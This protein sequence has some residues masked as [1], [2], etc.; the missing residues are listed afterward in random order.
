MRNITLPQIQQL[1]LEILK[2]FHNYCQENGLKYALYAGTLLGAIRHKGYIPWDDDIDIMMPRG[3][4]EKLY[5]LIKTK[6]L[7]APLELHSVRNDKHHN[8]P[9]FKVCDAR[10]D[11]TVTYLRNDIRCPVWIDIFPLDGIPDNEAER[12]KHLQTLWDIQKEMEYIV[13]PLRFSANPLRL[14]K[15][16][17][18]WARYHKKDYQSMADNM[19][20]LAQKYNYNTGANVAVA[21]FDGK[22]RIFKQNCMDNV[23]LADFEDTE[24]YIPADYDDFLFRMY[25]DYMTPPPK[26][27]QVSHHCY[28]AFWKE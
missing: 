9:F 4:Y 18:I 1:Q 8:A 17:Y 14:A 19:D 2:N 11:G 27:Q 22:K 15:R 5:E 3:D 28:T 24:F 12:N 21:V 10:T 6:P 16:L 26:E 23:V 20:K 7:P 25:G 13:R